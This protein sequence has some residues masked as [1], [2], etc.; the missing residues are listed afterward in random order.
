MQWVFRGGHG[1]VLFAGEVEECP[2]IGAGIGRHR[3]NLALLKQVALIVE[4]GNIAQM[5]S[6]DRQRAT[7]IQR[8]R[9]SASVT[10][11]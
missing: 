8:L 9:L 6:G 4:R 10:V 2:R 3:A 5:N 11:E 7:A 1:D